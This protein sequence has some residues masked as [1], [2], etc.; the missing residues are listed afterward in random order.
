MKIDTGR[1]ALSLGGATAVLWTICSAL[2]AIQPALTMSITAHMIH[3]NMDGF[4]WTLTL[5]GFFIGLIAWTLCA[6]VT[7]WLIGWIYNYF[8]ERSSG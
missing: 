5:A 8:G 6:A 2:V 3:A 1:L 7:G 4:G